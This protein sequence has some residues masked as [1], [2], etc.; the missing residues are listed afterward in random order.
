[1]DNQNHADYVHTMMI[2]TRDHIYSVIREEEEKEKEEEEDNNINKCR[3][4]YSTRRPTQP[5]TSRY[6][7]VPIENGHYLTMKTPTGLPMLSLPIQPPQPVYYT[8]P[9]PYAPTTESISSS[10]NYSSNSSRSR[11][12]LLKMTSQ[13]HR[14]SNHHVFW[15]YFLV[16]FVFM[17]ITGIAS[18]IVNVDVCF[19]NTSNTS[20]TNDSVVDGGAPFN[21]PHW[22][23]KMKMSELQFPLKIV[24]KTIIENVLMHLE[25]QMSVNFRLIN[26]GYP[27][28][29]KNKINTTYYPGITGEMATQESGVSKYFQ[30][31]DSYRWHFTGKYLVPGKIITI[32]IER[33]VGDI[34]VV[35][36]QKSTMNEQ[37]GG[38]YNLYK[39]QELL[40]FKAL[41]I[42]VG[43]STY[44]TEPTV[45]KISRVPKPYEEI[46]LPKLKP[47]RGRDGK[48]LINTFEFTSQIGGPLI[49][50][51][52][53]RRL[54]SR[55]QLPCNLNIRF[56][57]KRSHEGQLS[58][59]LV[60]MP[61]FNYSSGSDRYFKRYLRSQRPAPASVLSSNK[62]TL[63][64]RTAEIRHDFIHNGVRAVDVILKY[65]ITIENLEGLFNTA[66]KDFNVWFAADVQKKP[67]DNQPYTFYWK[68][69]KE[70]MVVTV[71]NTGGFYLTNTD[72]PEFSRMLTLTVLKSQK[73][74]ILKVTEATSAHYALR[75]LLDFE[76][77]HGLMHLTGFFNDEKGNM[78]VDNNPHFL[79]EFRENVRNK[80]YAGKSKW[81][82]NSVKSE[83]QLA[84]LID[85]L[86]TGSH[87]EWEGHHPLLQ[88]LV[89]R[90]T[91]PRLPV[92]MTKT[93]N[94]FLL[95]GMAVGYPSDIKPTLAIEFISTLYNKTINFIKTYRKVDSRFGEKAI[96]VVSETIEACI[97]PLV[98]KVSKLK[99]RYL[100]EEW[101]LP[102]KS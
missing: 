6:I 94:P 77:W 91:K 66:P 73:L 97:L 64:A 13:S 43:A 102:S 45:D 7:Q 75:R 67:D 31:G 70:Q 54:A 61:H 11:V 57:S 58:S 93:T 42:R 59:G 40:D 27:I 76:I 90:A 26:M 55:D 14:S 5:D 8:P 48:L 72:H 18:V 68:K 50:V 37:L 38:Q 52:Y 30:M 84:F 29:D 74:D 49:I 78:P 9:S 83:E 15:K 60:I 87:P 10:S 17:I 95:H 24:D 23:E 32:R 41:S 34:L 12:L 19:S 62:I 44:I 65:V 35:D 47:V 4:G 33:K 88:N 3:G 56:D 89:V 99:I 36:D 81:Y 20:T 51:Q 92:V 63:V 85:V 86:I 69:S 82:Y 96:A 71:P 46:R 16:A 80:V 53:R 101:G 79:Q 1:M 25:T 98:D 21:V 2:Q 100:M 22:Y 39:Y 28:S